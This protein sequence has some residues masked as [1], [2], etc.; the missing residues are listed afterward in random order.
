MVN[1]ASLRKIKNQLL[2]QKKELLN[3]S[4]RN[5]EM[6]AVDMDGDETDEIQGNMLIEL[7]NQLHTR[8]GA[9]LTQI[10]DALRRID[11]KTY[12][13]CEECGEK[14][15]D[16]RLLINPHFLTCISCAEERE[17][18]NKRMRGF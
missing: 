16:K 2:S 8:N 6:N 9:K 18:E 7:N 4:I 10:E 3:I 14:I 11:N 15:P 12:G 17:V 5:K 1:K 13:V